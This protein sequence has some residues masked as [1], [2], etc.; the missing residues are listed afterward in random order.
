MPV[1]SVAIIT[2][3]GLYLITFTQLNGT[4]RKI[5]CNKDNAYTFANWMANL[6][7]TYTTG[8]FRTKLLMHPAFP[9]RWSNACIKR[10]SRSA[11]IDIGSP[12]RVH[13]YAIR[14]AGQGKPVFL[15]LT[16]D[17]K[18]YSFNDRRYMPYALLTNY[19]GFGW[20]R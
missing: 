19:Y 16:R 3:Y 2:Q 18:K 13:R 10:I 9:R 15:I 1:V 20:Q 8:I 5:C 4:G 12:G 11:D 17:Q 7:S 14:T 6:L